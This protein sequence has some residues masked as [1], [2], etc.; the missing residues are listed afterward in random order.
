MFRC[1]FDRFLLGLLLVSCCNL[2]FADTVWPK[3]P[4][5]I[6]VPFPPGGS[7]DVI[8]RRLSARLTQTLGQPVIVENKGG[9]AGS[10]GAQAVAISPADGY[11]FLFVSSSL[12]TAS[13]VQKTPYDPARSFAAVARVA[14]APFIILTRTGFG[15][16]SV[17]ELVAYARANPGKINYG[18]AGPGDTTQ[19]ATELFNETVGVKMT[20]VPYKGIA[21]A[22]LD[23]IAGRL[24]L[25]VTTMA[26]VKGTAA[27]QLPKLAFTGE[28][29]EPDMPQIPTVAEAGIPYSVDVW[30]GVFAPAA[31]PVAVRDKMNREINSI[32]IEPDFVAFL[33]NAGASAAPT[34]PAAFQEILTKDVERWNIIAKRAGVQ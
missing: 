22:Q 26:S 2:S 17:P 32:L 24:D 4:V 14:R 13:A 11:T 20:A 10:I 31:V 18:S 23:L 34:T 19:M 12:A 5:H 27:D 33:K 28:A 15:P 8:A 1:L 21:P 25:I 29:R 3:A 9:G 30:W 16:K 6:V 7:N